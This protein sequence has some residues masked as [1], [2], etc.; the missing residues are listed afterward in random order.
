M[1]DIETVRIDV[2]EMTKQQ[3]GAEAPLHD[4][5]FGKEF[6]DE[7]SMN[8]IVWVVIGTFAATVLGLLVAWGVYKYSEH[9]YGPAGDVI[10]ADPAANITLRAVQRVAPEGGEMVV[11]EAPRGPLL[12]VY[13][14]AELDEM[15]AEMDAHLNGYGW[16]DES[17]GIVHV[18]IDR[19]IDQ[20]VASGL[21]S[22]AP[23]PDAAEAP[24]EIDLESP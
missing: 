2:G 13:P 5:R 23:A 1:A 21:P 18:P 6:D 11:Y 16:V 9:L 17:A 22:A 12:Q 24:I 3:D 10:A 15:Q 14:E 4:G 19:V 7:L 20:L 8:G